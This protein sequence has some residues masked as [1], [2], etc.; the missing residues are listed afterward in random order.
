MA[1]IVGI[2]CI[3]LGQKAVAKGLLLGAIFS[4][5]NFSLMARLN[6]LKLGQS[7]FR[8]G[9]WAGLY[10]GRGWM[11]CGLLGCAAASFSVSSPGS[12]TTIPDW[13]A[14]ESRAEELM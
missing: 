7:Q 9:F 6:L 13:A 8:A 2:A 14:V 1:V 3:L 4:T 11:E 12:L 5:I 10:R